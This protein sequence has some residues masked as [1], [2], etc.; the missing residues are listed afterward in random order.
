MEETSN[1]LFAG[2]PVFVD[3]CHNDYCKCFTT[4]KATDELTYFTCEEIGSTYPGIP[5]GYEAWARLKRT[6]TA[7]DC[8]GNATQGYQNIYLVRPQAVTFGNELLKSLKAQVAVN[9]TR[10]LRISMRLKTTAAW[11][12]GLRTDLACLV[13]GDKCAAPSAEEMLWLFKTKLRIQDLLDCVT[14]RG[15]AFLPKG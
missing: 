12:G 9:A 2:R 14:D 15:Y 5:S 13:G 8:Y 6:F 1:A 10:L 3:A 7:T 11:R 4:L